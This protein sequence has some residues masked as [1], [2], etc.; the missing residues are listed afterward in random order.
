[1]DGG[2][3]RGGGRPHFS[4]LIALQGHSIVCACSV[5]GGN[6]YYV[7]DLTAFGCCWWFFFFWLARPGREEHPRRRRERIKS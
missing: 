3:E 7:I 6:G 1:M 4:R 2:W 5:A